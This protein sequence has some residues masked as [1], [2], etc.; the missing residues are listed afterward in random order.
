MLV[1]VSLIDGTDESLDREIFTVK[2]DVPE[3]T[4]TEEL[5]QRLT[6]DFYKDVIGSTSEEFRANNKKTLEDPMFNFLHWV[7]VTRI[8]SE[9]STEAEFLAGAKNSMVNYHG[10]SSAEEIL[11][12]YVI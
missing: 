10:Y 7:N 12:D 5:S 2:M 3:D 6:A 9:T 8:P 1:S 4:D 11:G